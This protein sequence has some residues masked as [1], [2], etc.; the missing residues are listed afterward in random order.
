M[1]NIQ[2]QFKLSNGIS[3]P[4]IGLGTFRLKNTEEIVELLKVAF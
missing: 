1:E 4:K 2:T 3:M